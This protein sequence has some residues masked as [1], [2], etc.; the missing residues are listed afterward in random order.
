MH[1]TELPR[2]TS[3]PDLD[4]L[5]LAL[6]LLAHLGPNSLLIPYPNVA[7]GLHPSFEVFQ[8]GKIVPHNLPVLVQRLSEVAAEFEKLSSESPGRDKLR[9]V[10]AEEEGEDSRSENNVPI[11]LINIGFG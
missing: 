6:P 9:R 10:G 3:S 8:R 11:L 2:H 4:P 7:L 1:R 5:P